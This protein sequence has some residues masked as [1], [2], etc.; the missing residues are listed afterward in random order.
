MSILL[1]DKILHLK[2]QFLLR[3]VFFGHRPIVQHLT[4][5]NI[6]YEYIMPRLTVDVFVVCFLPAIRGGFQVS[7]GGGLEYST[8]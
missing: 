5:E 7:I 1:M 8:E 6:L 4:G 3:G 2:L